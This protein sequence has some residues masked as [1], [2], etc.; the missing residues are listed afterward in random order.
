MSCLARALRYSE[1]KVTACRIGNNRHYTLQN[2]CFSYRLTRG[3][4]GQPTSFFVHTVT[5]DLLY[6]NFSIKGPMNGNQEPKSL[7]ADIYCIEPNLHGVVYSVAHPG[8]Y[9]LTI[10]WNGKDVHGS[11]FTANI[12][13]RSD[14]NSSDENN[15]SEKVEKTDRI[16]KS[17]NS[18]KA[19]TT[20]V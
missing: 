12:R 20:N 18:E 3:V 1:C 10:K 16:E 13:I 5:L 4:V 6:L 8:Q 15:E 9:L 17:S 11:P 2:I 7:K 19:M 14:E